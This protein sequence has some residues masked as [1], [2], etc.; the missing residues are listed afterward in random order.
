MVN[1][2]KEINWSQSFLKIAFFVSLH[3]VDDIT[4]S[5]TSYSRFQFS[6]HMLYTQIFNFVGLIRACSALLLTN[7]KYLFYKIKVFGKL[8]KLFLNLSTNNFSIVGR[9]LKKYVF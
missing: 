6:L 4:S 1:I 9:I 8:V 2:W 7:Q 3:D 5:N